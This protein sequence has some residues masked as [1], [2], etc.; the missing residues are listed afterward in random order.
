MEVMVVNFCKTCCLT[1]SCL[2]TSLF[3]AHLALGMPEIAIYI[4]IYISLSPINRTG[5][6]CLW[7]AVKLHSISNKI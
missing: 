7:D 5:G 1:I 3:T 2:S 6:G 4:Y